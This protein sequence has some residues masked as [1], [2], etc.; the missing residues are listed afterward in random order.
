MFGTS[1]IQVYV[2]PVCIH[3]LV[4]QSLVVVRVHIAEIVSAG[5]RETRHGAGLQR[6]TL[7]GPVLC[8]RKRRFSGLGRLELVYL[9]KLQRQL[10][11]RK[12]GGNT[13]LEIDRERF[14]PIP[15]AGEYGV[16]EPVVDLP[17]ADSVLLD[18]F[19][20]RWDGILDIHAVEEAGIH[21]LAFLGIETRLAHVATLDQRDDRQVE[22]ACEGVVAAVVRRHGHDRSGTIA[23]EHIFGDPDRDPFAS[24]RIDSV[25]TA[26]Y[27]G[28]SLRLGDPLPFGLLLHIG[29]VFIDLSLLSRRSEYLHKVAFWSKHHEGDS[30]HGISTCSEYGHIMLL[31]PVV[32]LEYGFAAV[33][34]A[35]PV[36]LHLLEG[37]GPVNPFKSFEEPSGIS[38]NP[39]LPLLHHLLLNRKTTAYGQA[40]LD[41]VVGEHGSQAGAPVDRRLTLVSNAVVHQHVGL[42]LFGEGIP[43][44]C[45]E[46]VMLRTG[47]VDSLAPALG[48][49]VCQNLDRPGF[50]RVVVIPASEHHEESPLRPFV[51]LRITSPDLAVPVI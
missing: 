26:E 30:E 47:R 46:W 12:R 24:E 1:D 20:S 48:E 29:E 37:I 36:A 27:S 18:I 44:F 28:D 32:A 5:T 6:I 43:L 40:V 38:R 7:I 50:V 4:H 33:G 51:I 42:L 8:T 19:D 41:F 35:D 49:S 25:G 15:L 16:T 2:T 45:S 39:E 31:V 23:R 10:V 34:F 21:H 3:I 22:L 11:Q 13:V 17:V 14:T 9:R